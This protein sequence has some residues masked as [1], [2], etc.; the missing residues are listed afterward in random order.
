MRLRL[1]Y[2]MNFLNLLQ[3]NSFDFNASANNQQ[4]TL[5]FALWGSLPGSSSAAGDTTT[6][7]R[8]SRPR[9]SI[10]DPGIEGLANHKSTGDGRAGRP[11]LRERY[12]ERDREKRE[13]AGRPR[14]RRAAATPEHESCLVFTQA[15]LPHPVDRRYSLLSWS[16]YQAAAAA[17]AVRPEM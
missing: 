14:T 5:Y 13:R 1:S 9:P 10:S 15:L 17:A 2:L 4:H 6:M 8:L 3:K 11:R 12:G 16:V 7:P